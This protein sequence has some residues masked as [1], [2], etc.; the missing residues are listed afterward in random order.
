MR[1]GSRKEDALRD[2]FAAIKEGERREAQEAAATGGFECAGGVVERTAFLQDLYTWHR[3][4]GKKFKKPK[5][6]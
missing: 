2:A 1:C 5:K 3:T 4:C 6:L